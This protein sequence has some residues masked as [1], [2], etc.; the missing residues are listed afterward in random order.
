MLSEVSGIKSD[1]DNIVNFSFKVLESYWKELN[2]IDTKKYNNNNNNKNNLYIDAGLNITGKKIKEKIGSG[3]TLTN[4]EVKNI[5]KVIKSLENT[6]V[7]LKGAAIN[8]ISQ[9]GGFLNFLR[10]L[11]FTYASS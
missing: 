7:L 8:I 11:P 3:I 10:P 2:K 6:G 5:I 4:N 9:E 1:L